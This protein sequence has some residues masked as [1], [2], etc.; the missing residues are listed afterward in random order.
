MGLRHLTVLDREHRVK[1][2]ITRHDLTIYRLEHHWFSEGDNLQRF[3]NVDSFDPREDT[4]T[5][6]APNLVVKPERE[7]SDFSRFS[8]TTDSETGPKLSG[9]GTFASIGQSFG[10]DFRGKKDEDITTSTQAPPK[11]NKPNKEP[12]SNKAR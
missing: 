1:G 5:Y 6:V 8:L 7:N 11:D 2:I 12:K 10:F 4:D 9:G 3:M